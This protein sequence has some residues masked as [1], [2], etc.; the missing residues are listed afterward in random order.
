MG[1]ISP[2]GQRVTALR[3]QHG[4]SQRHLA[5]RAGVPHTVVSELERG[6]SR[7]TTAEVA[8]KLARALGAS[9]DFLLGTFDYLG[10]AGEESAG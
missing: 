10:V 2:Y 1:T 9:V 3:R 5:R 7:T 8:V 6:V 4:W